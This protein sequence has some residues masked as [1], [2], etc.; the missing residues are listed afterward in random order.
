MFFFRSYFGLLSDMSD[1]DELWRFISLDGGELHCAK[2]HQKG[3]AGGR[4]DDDN[5]QDTHFD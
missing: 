3:K 1:T 4:T 5:M 2:I